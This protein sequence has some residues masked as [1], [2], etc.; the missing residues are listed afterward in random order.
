MSGAANAHVGVAGRNGDLVTKID[1]GSL[2][3]ELDL[4]AVADRLDAAGGTL[5]IEDQPERGRCIVSSLPIA[6]L[7]GART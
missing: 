5:A 1:L 2:D 6:R 3:A 4:R 7:E